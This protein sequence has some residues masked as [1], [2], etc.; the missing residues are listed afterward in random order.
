MKRGDDDCWLEKWRKIW[1]WVVCSRRGDKNLKGVLWENTQEFEFTTVE[2]WYW[3]GR[4]G[5]RHYKN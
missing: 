5:G 2:R 4:N 3:A 1:K